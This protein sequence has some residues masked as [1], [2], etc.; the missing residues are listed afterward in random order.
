MRGGL[1]RMRCG[2]ST[3]DEDQLVDCKRRAR[4]P[5]SELSSRVKRRPLPRAETS[6]SRG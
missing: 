5:R 6:T 1:L 3:T 2:A 4:A